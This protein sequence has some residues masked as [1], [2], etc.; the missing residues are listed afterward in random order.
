MLNY[1]AVAL[2]SQVL[3]AI[4]FIIVLVWIW[5]K[6]IQPAV[7]V[8]QQNANAQ[9]AEAERHRDEAK[10][11]LESLRGEIDNARREAAAI[12]Q[13]VEAQAKAECEGMLDEARRAG[14]RSI[15]NAHG[16]LG[17]S[18]AAAREQLRDELLDKALTLARAQAHERVDE[19]VNRELVS[20]FVTTLERGGR[21]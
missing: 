7:I 18:R 15:A 3:S 1:E 5:I 19:R 6:F 16:E 12:R 10:A 21:N 20:S 11:Q 4:L 14:E 8:A 2:W 13:R 9:L 17:R